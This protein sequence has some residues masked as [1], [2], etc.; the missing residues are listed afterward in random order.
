MLTVVQAKGTGYS[1][2]REE[3][4]QTIKDVAVSTGEQDSPPLHKLAWNL[5]EAVYIRQ[6]PWSGLPSR[7]DSCKAE[8]MA[9][10]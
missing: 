10:A 4:L 1:I 2:S 6:T 3:E 9:S 8:S 5:P 7:Q